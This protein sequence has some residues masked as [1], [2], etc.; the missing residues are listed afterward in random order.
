MVAVPGMASLRIGALPGRAD[1][2]SADAAGAVAHAKISRHN[3]TYLM[4]G[5][6]I[7]AVL[8]LVPM[9]A[10][11]FRGD[12]DG[13]D[14]SSRS[15]RKLRKHAQ[16]VAT[17]EDEADMMDIVHQQIEEAEERDEEEANDLEGFRAPKPKRKKKKD[18][19]RGPKL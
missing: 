16:R 18:K 6:V 2:T 1:S 11:R 8:G 17:E 10:G 14:G 7:F 13:D 4:Y 5:A 12:A 15:R 9:I 19:G 3:L